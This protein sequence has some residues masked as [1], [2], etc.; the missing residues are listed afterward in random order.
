MCHHQK[1]RMIISSRGQLE[2]LCMNRMLINLTHV[3]GEN[4]HT[5]NGQRFVHPILQGEQN[6]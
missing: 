4:W 6:V 3:F 2:S 1:M 5:Q